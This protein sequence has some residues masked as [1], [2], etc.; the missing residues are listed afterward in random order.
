MHFTFPKSHRTGEECLQRCSDPPT[1]GDTPRR[2]GL[3]SG[4]ATWHCVKTVRRRRQPEDAR[5]QHAATHHPPWGRSP[6]LGSVPGRGWIPTPLG[7]LLCV[8]AVLFKKEFQ[9]LCVCFSLDAAPD[10]VHNDLQVLHAFRHRLRIGS[11]LSCC[12]LCNTR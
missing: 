12:I 8:A 11:I 10:E 9:F 5:A 3:S 4:W 6:A 7:T 2:L 1:S